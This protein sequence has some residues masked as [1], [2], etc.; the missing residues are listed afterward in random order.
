MTQ[1]ERKEGDNGVSVKPHKSCATDT[2]S[3][4]KEAIKNIYERCS[5]VGAECLIT[6]VA[7]VDK[8]GG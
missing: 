4:K 6:A 2:T 8:Q 3:H 1:S 7:Q 5:D